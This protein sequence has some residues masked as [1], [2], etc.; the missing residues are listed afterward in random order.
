MHSWLVVSVLSF[1]N[2]VKYFS[3]KYFITKEMKNY[4]MSEKIKGEKTIIILYDILIQRRISC[5]YNLYALIYRDV[6]IVFH[7]L[8]ILTMM[9]K[10]SL[11]Q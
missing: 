9:L 3:K 1:I 8:V 7:Q 5:C 2:I 11:T 4:Y 10:E 6:I